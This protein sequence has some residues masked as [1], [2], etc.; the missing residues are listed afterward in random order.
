MNPQKSVILM[1]LVLLA[2]TDCIGDIETP[3]GCIASTND[4]PYPFTDD[5]IYSATEDFLV[6]TGLDAD[7]VYGQYPGYLH[8]FNCHGYALYMIAECGDY[9]WINS[10]APYFETVDCDP[11][12]V[13]AE[14]WDYGTPGL[15]VPYSGEHSGVVEDAYTIRSKWGELALLDHAPT[16]VPQIEP[17]PYGS[18]G[19]QYYPIG[20]HNVVAAGSERRVHSCTEL[21]IEIQDP[22]DS[23]EYAFEGSDDAEDWRVLATAMRSAD[24]VYSVSLSE[25][26]PLLRVVGNSEDGWPRA[27]WTGTSKTISGRSHATSSTDLGPPGAGFYDDMPA[28]NNSYLMAGS[29]GNKSEVPK[30][31]IFYPDID[32]DWE[33]HAQGISNIYQ[34]FANVES[35]LVACTPGFTPV[36]AAA[37]QQFI[38]QEIQT[39]Y[40]EYKYVHLVGDA[41]DWEVFGADGPLTDD[42]WVDEWVQRRENLVTAYHYIDAGQPGQNF[43][44]TF[45][46]PDYELVQ[47]FGNRQGTMSALYPYYFSDLPY[48]DVDG[49]ELPDVA[50]SR[51]PVSSTTEL[52]SIMYKLFLH[53][54]EKL[55]SNGRFNVTSYLGDL[56][57]M[58]NSF[59]GMIATN[60]HNRVMAETG[61]GQFR[62]DFVESDWLSGGGGNLLEST[63]GVWNSSSPDAVIMTSTR[64]GRLDPCSM[65]NVFPTE[66]WDNLFSLDGLPVVV[67]APECGSGDFA[68]T[69]QFINDEVQTPVCER[70][71]FG[72]SNSGALTWIGPT[73]GSWLEK[74][75]IIAQRIVQEMYSDP[76]RPLAES[77]RVAI[78]GILQDYGD[79]PVVT[80]L[81]RSY[82]FLGDPIAN[83]RRQE[84]TCN[85]TATGFTT[86]L[87]EECGS[88]EISWQTPEWIACD[89]E[90]SVYG[91]D[92]LCSASTA[93]GTDHLVVW[94][95]ERGVR[96]RIVVTP[97]C[98]GALPAA[99]TWLVKLCIG[100]KSEA[101]FDSSISVSPNPS[102]PRSEIKFSLA[103]EDDI[104]VSVYDLKGRVINILHSGRLATGEHSIIWDGRDSSGGYASAGV[105]FV[106]LEIGADSYS[107]KFILVK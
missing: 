73:V 89:Y 96:Y 77:Y 45:V 72:D 21:E 4:Y 52:G 51:W 14:F 44:P 55:P 49:D 70:F 48:A 43:I 101:S 35:R 28:V 36:D 103:Q 82:A 40:P 98:E 92:V 50:I 26:T 86:M 27:L 23:S 66:N 81:A 97:R 33:S 29:R 8:S 11:S 94:R 71:M 90:I 38:M 83:F 54:Y 12:F 60:I 79:E 18:P 42:F 24:N 78:R 41:N 74:N 1:I 107:K 56:E 61:A 16:E 25:C 64:S 2:S 84:Q 31:L 68:S 47:T 87:L 69:E 20:D 91:G 63:L 10:K 105:Y 32:A 30:V 85:M 6:T 75:G 65:F 62:T 34:Y 13:Q 22:W 95:G 59:D 58:V 88:V 99:H 5:V 17:W 106:K 80:R 7:I 53:L 9:I 100:Q 15:I 39:S 104:E 37:T 76:D 102:N 93:P 19:E 3:G 67:L 46:F 57:H